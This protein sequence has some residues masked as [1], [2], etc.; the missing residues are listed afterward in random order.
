MQT[1]KDAL[2]AP[3]EMDGAIVRLVVEY[4]RELEPLIDESEL[5]KYTDKT[6]EFHL[7]KRPQ[8]EARIRLPADKTVSSLSPLDLLDLYWRSS[9]MDPADMEAL[10]KLA[11]EILS[12]DNGTALKLVLN[13]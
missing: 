2:P 13:E 4:P 8:I 10:H 5:R 7:V 6:F 11:S 1:L 12:K 9:H 3:K